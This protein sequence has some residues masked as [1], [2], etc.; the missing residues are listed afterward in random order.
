[1]DLKQ[2][3]PHKQILFSW[4]NIVYVLHTISAVQKKKKKKEGFYQCLGK[5]THFVIEQ[6]LTTSC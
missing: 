3:V 4:L 6:L 1:M 5:T 2:N